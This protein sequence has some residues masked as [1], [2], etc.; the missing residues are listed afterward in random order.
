MNTAKHALLLLST[1][2]ILAA[3]NK[4]DDEDPLPLD[5]YWQTATPE[6]QGLQTDSINKALDLAAT[7][8][9]FF[10]LLVIKNN[11]LIAERYY[12]GK[13]ANS[14]L[15]LRSITKNFTATMA[16]KAIEDGHLNDLSD[17]LADYLPTLATGQKADIQVRHLLN[18]TAGLQWDENAEVYD[19][20]QNN[21][22]NPVAALL[23]RDLVSTPG[24]TFNYNSVLSHITATIIEQESQQP[25]ENYTNTTLLQP[26]GI[27]DYAWERESAGSVWGGFGLQLTARDLAKFGQLYLNGGTWQGTRL[28]PETWVQAS[29][30]R[31]TDI[32]ETTGYSLHWWV[33][34]QGTRLLYYGLG[35]GG[36]Y[37]LLIPE[38][39]MIILAMQE[40]I[41]SGEQASAQ[42][43]RFVSQLF[44]ILRGAIP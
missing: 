42:S 36:Q 9:N 15:H 22:D 39:N 26:L 1:L 29:Q 25:L 19:L 14:L 35:Y 5:T 32:S 7:Y 20:V 30:E 10:A 24:E 16:G 28:I 37:L 38:Q 41:V 33:S 43:S 6:S 34:D 31:Q 23:N 40:H 44:P 13:N 3:C 18:M 4:N 27:S 21:I 2:L 12:N 8:D 17:P 11:R